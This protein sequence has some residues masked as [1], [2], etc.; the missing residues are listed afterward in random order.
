MRL[1]LVDVPAGATTASVLAAGRARG[2]R[3]GGRPVPA[4]PAPAARRRRRGGGGDAGGRDVDGSGP[5]AAFPPAAVAAAMAALDDAGALAAG[6]RAV[7]LGPADG[8]DDRGPVPG[9]LAALARCLGDA[10]LTVERFRIDDGPRRAAAL[11]ADVVVT[12]IGEPGHVGG[13][14]VA[15]GDRGRR[16]RQPRRRPGR[17]RRRPGLGRRDGGSPG[18]HARRARAADGG[19]PARPRRH[20]G[21]AAPR[22]RDLTR[23]TAHTTPPA[24]D[25][26]RRRWTARRAIP[27]LPRSGGTPAAPWPRRPVRKV[28]AVAVDGDVGMGPPRWCWPN[29][30]RRGPCPGGWATGPRS[31]GSAAAPCCW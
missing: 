11:G 27:R 25:R 12:A 5:A 22:S 18:A 7:L 31:T 17:R 20:G 24:A 30:V 2:R 23:A 13:A 29:R 14:D 21:R 15:P 1:R 28:V 10:G 16:R 4:V 26:R 19:G 8:R 6:R 3:R 9:F